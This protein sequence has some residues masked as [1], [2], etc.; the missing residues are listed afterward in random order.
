MNGWVRV[1][2]NRWVKE[3]EAPDKEIDIMEDCS[4]TFRWGESGTGELR[5]KGWVE[6]AANLKEIGCGISHHGEP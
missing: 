3:L 6:H 5:R 1:G 4:S 2:E